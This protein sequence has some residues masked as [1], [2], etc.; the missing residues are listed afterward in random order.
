VTLSAVITIH[1]NAFYERRENLYSQLSLAPPH[2]RIVLVADGFNLETRKELSA[3]VGQ[4]RLKNVKLIFGVFGNP[5]DARNAGIACVDSDWV[6]FW[7]SDDCPA[8]DKFLDL[9]REA[10]E[11]NTDIAKGSYQ[12]KNN[13]GY[14]RSIE[15]TLL[16]EPAAFY[17]HILDP[18]IWRYIFSR[19]IYESIRFPGLRIG[20]DQN[21]IV[22]AFLMKPKLYCSSEIVYTYSIGNSD[23]ITQNIEAF[24]DVGYSLECLS[25]LR[26]LT[27]KSDPANLVILT[28]YFKQLFTGL[29]RAGWG[30]S[31]LNFRQIFKVIFMVASR[32][33]TLQA[34]KS[35]VVWRLRK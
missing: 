28:A 33:D 20:E 25:T 2:L 7:D 26:G 5:G 29:K 1:L 9:M 11:A 6:C 30:G 17:R 27:R 19:R 3:H 18:G 35:L 8:P 34:L 16:I 4:M 15:N 12:T 21:F 32:R 24:K 22:Q 10:K 23:Q 31:N 13:F 14:I